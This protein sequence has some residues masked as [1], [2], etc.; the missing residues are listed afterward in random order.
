MANKFILG[1]APTNAAEYR[2]EQLARMEHNP[3]LCRVTR[4]DLRERLSP[5]Y[6]VANI[7]HL[8]RE[9]NLSRKFVENVHHNAGSGDRQVMLPNMMLAIWL[10]KYEQQLINSKDAILAKREKFRLANLR[11]A[12][13]PD[14]TLA[15][16][17]A[18]LATP[19]PKFSG[20]SSADLA[21]LARKLATIVR[22]RN[23]ATPPAPSPAPQTPQLETT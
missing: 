23:G 13:R 4:A 11:R 1:F 21:N 20:T 3:A 19:D 6:E 10:D 22:S 16:V 2:D 8:C 15:G 12:N 14:R 5:L 7:A 17:A 18:L 9:T